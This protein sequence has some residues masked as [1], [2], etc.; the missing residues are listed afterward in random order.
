[1]RELHAKPGKWLMFASTGTEWA[2]AGSGLAGKL[3]VNVLQSAFCQE[4]TVE[5]REIA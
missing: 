4:L 1:M 5:R 2:H 3:T